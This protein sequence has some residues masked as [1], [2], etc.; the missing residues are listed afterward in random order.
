MNNILKVAGI[1]ALFSIAF[2]FIVTLIDKSLIFAGSVTWSIILVGII[3]LIVAGRKY[4]RDPEDGF[5]SY[6]EAFK[7]LLLACVISTL[8]VQVVSNLR[9]GNDSEM[10]QLY[11]TYMMKT[12]ESAMRMTLNLG[13]VDAIEIEAAVEKAM[14]DIEQ[15]E[16]ENSSYPY[17]W[18]KLPLTLLIGFFY[19]LLF[20]LIA[21]IFVRQKET[22]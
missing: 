15:K 5:L 20:S 19:S 2:A 14:Q 11:K 17:T 9:F 8:I 22:I 4:F 18:A 10:K 7:K 6:G 21:A 1:Y 12:S 13:Q 16:K 3:V